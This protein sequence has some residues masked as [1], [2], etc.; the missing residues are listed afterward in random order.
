M[1]SSAE[2]QG[3]ALLD[4]RIQRWVWDA[5]WASLRDVQEQAIPALLP[6]QRDVILAAATAAG[7][8][9]AA[10]LPI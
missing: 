6:A 3:F 10:F 5:G 2:S 9:E 1:S 8:T 4:S 7:K